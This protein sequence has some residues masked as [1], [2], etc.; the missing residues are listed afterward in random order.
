M[1]IATRLR[2]QRPTR[3]DCPVRWRHDI[4]WSQ[5]L[6]DHMAHAVV[7]PVRFD[8]LPAPDTTADRIQGYD[9]QHA[10]CYRA[11]RYV[12]TELR[13]DD[14][15]SYYVAPV[16]AETLEAWR[17]TDQRWLV[18]HTRVDDYDAGRAHHHLSVQA[19][20]PR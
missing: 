14:D 19:G 20:M 16:Y 15:E 18:L 9:A 13:S 7:A 12:R 6:P 3:A 4:P 2:T 5:D 1:P 17:L 11:Y 8:V 10:P